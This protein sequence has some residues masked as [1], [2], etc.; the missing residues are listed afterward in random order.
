METSDD[1]HGFRTW[2]NFPR[3]HFAVAKDNYFI[4]EFTDDWSLVGDLSYDVPLGFHVCST[5]EFLKA[6]NNSSQKTEFIYRNQA[7]W[8]EFRWNEKWRTV[9]LFSD[10]NTSHKMLHA[11]TNKANELDSLDGFPNRQFAGLVC[12]QNRGAS[13]I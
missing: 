13:S 2:K 4:Y 12:I 7:E 9:F 11:G 6:V 5:E 10:S 8:K 1:A 3:I